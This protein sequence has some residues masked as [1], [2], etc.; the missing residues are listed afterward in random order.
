VEL[1]FDSFAVD[2]IV[3]DTATRL[4]GRILRVDRSALEN[5]AREDPRLADVEVDAVHPGDSARILHV[6]DAVEPRARL[7]PRGPAFPGVTGV[8]IMAGQGRTAR[9]AGMAVVIAG[10]PPGAENPS[11]WQESIIDMTGPGA[12]ACP[13]SSVANLVLTVHPDPR[14]P[15]TEGVA[16]MRLAG[17]R[18]AE[19][20]AAAVGDGAPASRER[21]TLGPTAADSPRVAAV[22][23]LESWGTLQH[24]FLYGHGVDGLL[25][26]LLHP[27]EVLDGALTA[28]SHHLPAIRNCTYFFQNHGL[29]RELLRRHG[30]AI[31]FAGVV[32]ARAMWAADEDKRRAAAFTAKLLGQLGVVGAVLGFA[33]GGHAVTD[34]ALTAEA[35]QRAGIAVAT[36]MFE[37]SGEDGTDFSL[38]QRVPSAEPLVSTGNIDALLPVSR[39]DR[40]VGGSEVLGVGGHA[41]S[42][43]EGAAAFLL[44]VRHVFAASIPSGNG[45][46]AGAAG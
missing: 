8:P 22:L 26:T 39:V 23:H 40:V 17:F 43:Q 46:L 33:H 1:D 37:M 16:A 44:P 29:V 10:L 5:H 15:D 9:L 45:R 35:C 18:V 14:L 34:T 2:R 12:Q 7:E 6:V 25:P 3:L 21:L 24:T 30:A 42:R 19:Y 27:N 20:L 36:V 28:G 41:S 38:V 11:F 32:V 13:L 4:E 31:D